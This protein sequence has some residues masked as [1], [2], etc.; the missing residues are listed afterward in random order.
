MYTHLRAFDLNSQ[1]QNGQLHLL[2]EHA[3]HAPKQ[4]TH[5]S[6]NPGI[7]P[8][9]IHNR[10][11]FAQ[12]WVNLHMCYIICKT[13]IVSP[14]QISNTRF[15]K[16]LCAQT[17]KWLCTYSLSFCSCSPRLLVR[18]TRSQLAHYNL[19]FVSSLWIP[20]H[21]DRLPHHCCPQRRR[22]RPSSWIVFCL[23]VKKHTKHAQNA[24]SDSVRDQK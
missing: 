4:L 15:R 10:I 18:Q 8:C 6:M 21:H 16:R 23:S 20:G 7:E 1:K 11:I 9:S 13:A 5:L 24:G 12:T 3:L 22:T 17:L 2:E 19:L 14:L